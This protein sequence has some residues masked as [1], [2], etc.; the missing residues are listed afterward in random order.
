M[1]DFIIN[2]IYENPTY[3]KYY[4]QV[5]VLIFSIIIITF[6]STIIY[7]Y[8]NCNL[9]YCLNGGKVICYNYLDKS[10]SHYYNNSTQ[11]CTFLNKQKCI[12]KWSCSYIFNSKYYYTQKIILQTLHKNHD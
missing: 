10:I 12:Y 9:L 8:H 6:C 2:K 3:L 1:F 7:L 11:D 4:K 5:A